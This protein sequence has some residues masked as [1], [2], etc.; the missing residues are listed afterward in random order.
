MPATN[1]HFFRTLLL[2]ILLGVV[3]FLFRPLA[4]GYAAF[5]LPLGFYFII[6][7]RNANNE[8]LFWSAYVVA[9]E[10]FLRMTKGNIGNEYAK[11]GVIIFML[12]GIYFSKVSAKSRPYFI[13]LLLLIPGIIIGVLNL[14]FEAN[15]RKALVF[16]LLGP[17]CLA[18]SCIYTMDKKITIADID[19]ITRWMIYPIAAMVI[20]MFLYNPSIKDVVTGTD[21][22]SATSGGFGPNQVSTMLGLG[23]FI[24]FVRLLFFSKSLLLLSFNTFFLLVLSYRGLITFSRGGVYTGVAMILLLLLATYPFISLK[25]KMKINITAAL[26]VFFGISVFTYSISQTGGMILN[27]YK[28]EDAL[29]REKASQFSGRE[30]LAEAEIQM[31]MDNPIMGIGVGKNKEYRQEML[32]ISGASHNEITRMLAEHG[33]LGIVNLLILLI[34]P[35]VLYLDNKQHIFLFSFFIF[36]FL[37]INHASMRIAAPAFIYSLTLLKLI[38]VEKPA[39]HRE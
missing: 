28:G 13:Y 11:Y 5:I 14:S 8:V 19:K 7:N 35:F 36:W 30:E 6:K 39:L 22:N 33:S 21:S 10:V 34:T 9:A 1:T 29:G 4:I 12:L 27:R 32:G 15:I 2:H 37:T 16:N 20:Y 38:L 3:V 24:V 17:V 18:I 31:F 25:G 26:L 23:M